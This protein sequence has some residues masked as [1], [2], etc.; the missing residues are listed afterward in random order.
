V[1]KIQICTT[2]WFQDFLDFFEKELA[3]EERLGVW[4]GG[5]SFSTA[6]IALG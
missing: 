5:L 3:A 4:L 6:D 1:K 2:N